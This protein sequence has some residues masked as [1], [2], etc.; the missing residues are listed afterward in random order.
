MIFAKAL[1]VVAVAILIVLWYFDLEGKLNV[2]YL[3]NH[4]EIS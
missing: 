3:L 1:V 4:F 2:C